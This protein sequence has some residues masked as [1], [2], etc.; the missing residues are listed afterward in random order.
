MALKLYSGTVFFKDKN[1]HSVTYHNI[2]NLQNFKHFAANKLRNAAYVNFY[3]KSLIKGHAN[4]LATPPVETFYVVPVF[5]CNCFFA[6]K[7]QQLKEYFVV[8]LLD[9]EQQAKLVGAKGF[10]V[11]NKKTKQFAGTVLF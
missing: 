8:D 3:E 6:N 5:I 9:F 10:N 4:K 2:N 1:K 11:Y 7:S